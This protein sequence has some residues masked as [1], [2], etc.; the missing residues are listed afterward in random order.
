MH[1]VVIFDCD[2]VLVDSEYLVIEIE[3]DMLA[4]LGAQISPADIARH[5]TGLSDAAMNAALASDWG[6]T[7][8]ETFDAERTKRATEAFE[9][10]LTPVPGIA[11]VLAWLSLPR[12]VASSSA[13]ERISS[14]LS[15]TGLAGYFGDHL[16]SAAM[17]EHGKPAPDLFLFAANKLHAPPER[18]I[19]IEDSPH[20]VE[21]GR[22][23]GMHVIGFT[24]G[25]HCTPDHAERLTAA[26]AHAVA[27]TSSAL[28]L[29]LEGLTG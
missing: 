19:V 16:Y 1:D 13:P 28:R 11:D 4:E 24:A 14:S 29:V 26:G 27:A 8:P 20:G 12:C 5:F 17:V 6:V 18:C 21:A 9:Q 22:A 15:L 23:A 10:S 2:G 7:L 25:R 3:S